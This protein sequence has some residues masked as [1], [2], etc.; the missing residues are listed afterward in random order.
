MLEEELV[1]KY[2][3][4]CESGELEEFIDTEV[5]SEFISSFDSGLQGY[6]YKIIIDEDDI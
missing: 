2:Y 1:K 5:K 4:L 3:E 6:V